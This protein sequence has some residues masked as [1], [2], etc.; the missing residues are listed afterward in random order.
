MACVLSWEADSTTAL[1]A[2]ARGLRATELRA[3][4]SIIAM[5]IE[6]TAGMNKEK[7]DRKRIF[8]FEC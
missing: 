1:A 5:V 7:V 4:P 6:V 8:L 2:L 3:I